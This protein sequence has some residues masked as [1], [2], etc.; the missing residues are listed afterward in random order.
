MAAEAR[1]TGTLAEAL[2]D[3]ARGLQSEVVLL[4]QVGG[5]SEAQRQATVGND[6]S[7]LEHVSAERDRLTTALV[8]LEAQLRPLRALISGNLDR[9]KRQPGF[10]A[11]L[12]LHREAERLVSSILSEDR[13][14]LEALASAERT[15]RMA[16]RTIE[17]GEATLA[18]YR[19][20]VAPGPGSASL[21]DRRG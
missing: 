19:R 7:A 4:R 6:M 3:Y 12:E 20:V 17:A 8:T 16:A 21:V 9:A 5:L 11:V 13:S 2:H 14:T 15:R 1:P 10:G 18:A